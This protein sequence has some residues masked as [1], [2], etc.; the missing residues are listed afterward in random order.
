[1]LFFTHTSTAVLRTVNVLPGDTLA[2]GLISV[3]Q[4]RGRISVG[5]IVCVCPVVRLVNVTAGL[6]PNTHVG[7]KSKYITFPVFN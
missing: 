6:G 7:I 2:W 1:M 4:L 5:V 3:G